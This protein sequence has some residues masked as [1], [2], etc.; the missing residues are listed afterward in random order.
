M[1]IEEIALKLQ[2]TDDRSVSN[3]GR[4]EKLEE[5]HGT[6]HSLA[7]SVAV[8]VEQMKQM[9]ESID[10]L[11]DEVEEIKEKPGKRWDAL[12]DKIIWA[13]AGAIVAFLLAKLG[14]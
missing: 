6:L 1:N 5:E 8:M 13:V 9:N 14:I 3:E 12:V 11:S 7:T 2:K 10:T 4:I